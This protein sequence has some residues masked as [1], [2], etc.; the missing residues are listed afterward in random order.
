MAQYKACTVKKLH[1]KH[2][3]IV[4]HNNNNNI[5]IFSFIY[6]L[7]HRRMFTGKVWTGGSRLLQESNLATRQPRR[8]PHH[9]IQ[10]TTSEGL[11]QGPYMVAIVGFEP[12]TFHTEG[13]EHHHWATTPQNTAVIAKKC[14]WSCFV[15]NVTDVQCYFLGLWCQYGDA[16]SMIVSHQG[17]IVYF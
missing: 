7:T 1:L 6:N 8:A 5:I 2:L 9:V 17:Y 16:L 4:S 10:T 11:A 15:F 12:E 14:L 3:H 13:T